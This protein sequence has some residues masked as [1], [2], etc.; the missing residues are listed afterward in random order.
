[1]TKTPEPLCPR[2]PSLLN[3]LR[4]RATLS[5]QELAARTGLT[6]NDISR[7]ERGRQIGMQKLVSLA[8]YLKITLDSLL[9]DDLSAVFHTFTQPIVP[10]HRFSLRQEQLNTV[11]N[12]L[13][14]RGEDWVYAEE[15]KKL[16]GLPYANAVNPNYADDP[17]AG[18]DIMSFERDGTP[19]L[20]EVKTTSGKAGRGFHMAAAEYQKAWACMAQGIRY[21][22]HC[23][24]RFGTTGTGRVIIPAEKLFRDFTF[25]PSEYVVSV[26][27]ESGR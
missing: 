22:V 19:V 27:R 15:L 7:F 24:H 8:K 13:G 12:D 18:F 1:M 17:E 3:Y 9:T 2:Q 5:Q 16:D 14:R 23:V 4:C 10:S 25:R 20:I 21:E 6:A 26:R 11:K